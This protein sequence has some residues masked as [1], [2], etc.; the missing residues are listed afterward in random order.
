[1]TILAHDIRNHLTLLGRHLDIVMRTACCY[2]SD[3]QS[4][5]P[6]TRP[7]WFP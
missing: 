2:A 5:M 7:V 6:L 1:M 3:K 4:L